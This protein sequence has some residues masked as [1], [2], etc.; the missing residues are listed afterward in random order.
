MSQTRR[1][2]R[3]QQQRNRSQ[4]PSPRR[5]PQPRSPRPQDIE[6]ALDSCIERMREVKAQA[7]HRQ[8]NA[9]TLFER[10]NDIRNDFQVHVDQG[11]HMNPDRR[12]AAIRHKLERYEELER[13]AFNAIDALGPQQGGRRR[14][15]RR[16][17]TRRH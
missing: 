9:E 13:D 8:R 15:T 2:R 4:T 7:T 17:G 3:R 1:S 10:A 12:T 6:Q 11:L 5:S 14:A 16:R